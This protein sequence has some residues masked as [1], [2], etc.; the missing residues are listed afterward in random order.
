MKPLIGITC[1]Y[2]YDGNFAVEYGIGV[3][4]QQWHLLPHD[5]IHAVE[6]AGGVPVILP[7]YDEYRNLTEVIRRLDGVLFAGGNDVNPLFYGIHPSLKTGPVTPNRDRQEIQLARH[8]IEETRLPVFFI[9]RGNQILNVALG[10]TLHQD[11]VESRFQNHSVL[12]APATEVCHAIEISAGSL[13][14]QLLGKDTL[15]VNSL[16]HQAVDEVGNGLL[17]SA[18]AAD[19][20]VEALELPHREGFALAVQWHPEMLVDSYADHRQLLEAFVATA[21]EPNGHR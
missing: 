14:H 10:G 11:L 1:K 8:L 21:G 20:V 3:P 7:V 15:E 4:G 13:L 16:H 2:S 6:L 5:Y 18:R 9:C 19:G 12:T 17:V